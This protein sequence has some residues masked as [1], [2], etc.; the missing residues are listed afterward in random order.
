MK[1]MSSNGN[2][3]LQS[4]RFGSSSCFFNLSETST[5]SSGVDWPRV[6]PVIVRELRDSIEGKKKDPTK[7]FA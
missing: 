4:H 5:P 6:L 1:K 2:F 3:K 7:K